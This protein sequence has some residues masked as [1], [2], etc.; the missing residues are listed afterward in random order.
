MTR[1]TNEVCLSQS[2]GVVDEL[3]V[4]A[5][6]AA[7]ARRF[8]NFIMVSALEYQKA[9][10]SN[11]KKRLYRESQLYVCEE[12]E[13]KR[14]RIKFSIRKPGTDLRLRCG[15][16]G[17]STAASNCRTKGRPIDTRAIATKAKRC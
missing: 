17:G 15:G 10:S 6:L 5:R 11:C 9:R 12:K 14:A 13:D 4:C 16:R 8:I 3:D 7:A 2:G 1:V